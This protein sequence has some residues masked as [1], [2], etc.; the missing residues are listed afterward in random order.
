MVDIVLVTPPAQEPITVNQVKAQ[1]RIFIAADDDYINTITI[2]SARASVEDE[3]RRALI[4]QTWL[5]KMDGFPGFNPRYESH[6]YPTIILPKPPCQSIVEFTYRDTS[7][8]LQTLVQCNPDGTTP[9]GQFYG[10]QFDPG[11]ETQPGRLLP[12]WARPWPPSRR[13][14][15]AVQV[16]FNSGYGPYGSPATWISGGIPPAIIH[17]MLLQ[18]AHLYANREAVAEVKMYELTRGVKDLIAPY[19]NYIA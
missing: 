9:D 19:V 1:S 18:A 14:P 10:Y 2:P 8:V 12:P 5:L 4:T 7:G 17:A 13:M 6:G 15:M 11:S 16:T 3:L